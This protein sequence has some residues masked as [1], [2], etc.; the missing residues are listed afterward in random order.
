MNEKEKEN[1]VLVVHIL[2]TLILNKTSL[3]LNTAHCTK[4]CCKQN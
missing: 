4:L 2:I 1:V 3:E